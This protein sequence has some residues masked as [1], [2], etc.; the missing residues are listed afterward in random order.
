MDRTDWQ[1]RYASK[2]AT[3]DEAVRRIPPGRTIFIGSGAA[4]PGGLVEALVRQAA[5]FADNTIVHLMT[6]GPAPY[7]APEHEGRFRHNAFFIGANVR[8]AIAEGR[9]DYTPVFLSKIPELIRSRRL[10]VHAALIQCSPPDAFG[11]VNLGVSVD[12]IPAA[13]EAA[14]IVIAEVN[15]NVPRVHGAGFLPM[16]AIHWWTWNDAPLPEHRPAPP[17]EVE[18]EIG[19]NVASLIDDG[20][21]IQTG[22]GEI[23]DAVLRCLGDRRDLGVW[24][25]MFSDGVLELIEKGVVTGRHATVFPGKVT[26]SFTLGSR[27]LYDFVDQNPRFSFQPS[28]FVNDPIRIARQHRM[29]AINS[30]LEVDLTG[31]VCADSI[32]TK[33]YSGIGGQ[34]DFIRGASMCPDGKPIIAMRSTARG[35]TIS[36]IVPT[37]APGAGVVTS[38]GDVRYVV[39]EHGVADLLGKSIRERA[40]A[41]IAIAHPDFRGELLRA[42]KERRYVFFDEPEPRGRYPRELERRVRARTGEVLLLRPIRPT[43]E[44]KLADL[45]YSA[46]PETL[47]QRF[48]SAIRGVPH[49]GRREHL[50]VDYEARLALVIETSAPRREP[51]LLA[52]AQLLR[53]PG[54][55]AAEIA[56]LVRDDWQGR[57]LATQLLSELVGLARE[58]GLARLEAT[59]R[60]SNHAMLRV[61]ERCGLP[62][63]RE[64]DGDVYR[65]R[66]ALPAPA[67]AGLAPAEPVPDAGR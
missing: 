33:F 32:G 24:T 34:V 10:P 54:E 15:P 3:P 43:D 47:Q 37:L 59:A 6:L 8:R 7:V 38:R 51:E 18:M 53:E 4:E 16:D 28:D 65:L 25:E 14:R 42:A 20:S 35:G 63:E 23:P 67:A 31:Q 45:F 61:F 52:V 1:E 48:L 46:S 66:L 22:I 58:R 60:T 19:R 49:S 50:D 56:F 40:V 12:V 29:A 27:R 55:P 57:G 30:A 21:T 13:V 39:T 36:R 26:A 5:H 62:L 9:G 64:R 2:R 44:P 11:F 41:L 17:S